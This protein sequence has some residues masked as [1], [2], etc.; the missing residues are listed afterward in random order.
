MRLLLRLPLDIATSFFFA[1]SIGI[2][3]S[4]CNLL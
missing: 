3:A 2:A 4:S 1:A